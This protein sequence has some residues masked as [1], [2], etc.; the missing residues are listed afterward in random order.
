M[1]FVVFLVVTAMLLA[2]VQAH[3]NPNSLHVGTDSGLVV[4]VLDQV[5]ADK[6]RADSSDGNTVADAL[7]F[8]TIGP[9]DLQTHA[10]TYNS[11]TG[12]AGTTVRTDPKSGVT[13]ITTQV[14]AGDYAIYS[15][16]VQRNWADCF[17]IET[18]SFHV[19][20]GSINY[21]G[22][23][24]PFPASLRIFRAVK[25][26]QM[27][28]S[29]QVGTQQEITGDILQGLVPAAEVPGGADIV[30]AALAGIKPGIYGKPFVLTEPIVTRT[31]L[32]LG[33][34]NIYNYRCPI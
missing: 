18:A 3:A 5:A 24:N 2:G 15:Q 6:S 4:F 26:G 23:Y 27:P 34:A 10:V 14:K 31:N 19:A 28:Q 13:L 11:W 20:P 33:G 29:S 9:I 8:L 32:V 12:N 22:N 17:D 16:T 30:K 7:F 25:N 21:I 1:R